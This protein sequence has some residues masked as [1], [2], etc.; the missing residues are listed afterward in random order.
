MFAGL[1][2]V[3]TPREAG[4]PLRGNDSCG[5]MSLAF[6]QAGPALFVGVPWLQTVRAH[7]GPS[8]RAFVALLSAGPD[9]ESDTNPLTLLGFGMV[10]Y[11]G[12]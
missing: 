2:L 5:R 1:G 10:V 12:G 7:M 9:V 11:R 8:F 4:S 3:V 6:A